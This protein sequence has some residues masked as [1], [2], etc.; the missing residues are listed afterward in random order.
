M[1]RQ[2]VKCEWLKILL[3]IHLFWRYATH[4]PLDTS[5][6][7]IRNLKLFDCR[8][9]GTALNHYPEQNMYLKPFENIAI[10]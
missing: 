1:M 3:Y 7:L 2:C 6:P 10:L 8:I 5:R 4:F 9:E